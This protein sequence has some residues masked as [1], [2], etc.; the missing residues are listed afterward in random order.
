ME[1]SH[2]AFNLLQTRRVF[3]LRV[4]RLNAVG[5]GNIAILDPDFQ[6]TTSALD[7]FSLTP[8]FVPTP[9]CDPHPQILRQVYDFVRKLQWRF[10]FSFSSDPPRF[11]MRNSSRWPPTKSV[12]S[13][14]ARM[15]RK[16]IAGARELCGQ[17]HQCHFPDNLTKSQQREVS[18]LTSCN[19]TV[20][21]ADKGGRWTVVPTSSYVAEAN[22]QLSNTT[23]YR[24]IDRPPAAVRAKMNQLL[25]HL[26]QRKFITRREYNHF[27]PAAMN[28]DTR[29]FKLLPKLHKNTWPDPHMPPGRPI[30]SDVKSISRNTSELI[31]FFLKPL[32]AKLP[33]HLR[34]T[35]HLVAILRETSISSSSL[36][37]TLDVE[38]LYTSIPIDEGLEAVSRAF[39]ANPSTS[40]PDLTILSLLRLILTTNNF[41]FNGQ[42]WLQ[43]HG[44]AMGKV[45]GGS[46][47]NTFL[48]QWEKRAISTFTHSVSLWRRFQDDI[49]GIWDHGE[50]L[51]HQFVDHLNEQNSNIRVQLKYGQSV[52]FLDLHITTSGSTLRYSVFFKDT[53][54]H[55]ILPP[56][57]HHPASTFDGLLYGEIYRFLT[58]SSDFDSFS[59]TLKTVTPVW[60]AQGYPR[61]AIRRAKKR[62]MNTTQIFPTREPGMFP[63]SS[64]RCLVCPYANFLNVFD[65]FN[66]TLSYPIL[67]FLTCESTSVVYVIECSSCGMRYVGQTRRTLR[68]RILE[69]LRNISSDSHSRLYHHFRNVCK[70]N[71][72]TF[73]AISRHN[74]D[75]T[76]LAKE[77]AWISAL[78]TLHPRG[79]NSVPESADQPTN[80]ILPFDRCAVRLANAIRHWTKVPFRVTYTRTQNI[81]E[82]LSA[83]P[84]HR[85]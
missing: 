1:F 70:T 13:N 5:V 11:R 81:G 45:F 60:R 75:S 36:L 55:L 12:P 77:R 22:R 33:S 80:L 31:D 83:R 44:V 10:S 28:R 49:L 26:L 78:C 82:L 48:G 68:E 42:E 73:F 20:T 35:Q 15:S 43:T 41:N 47:A 29:S 9:Y 34:D 52:D 19:S 74:N 18:R 66:N 59:A 25:R 85:N 62:V 40:R 14:I 21:S 72:F 37:F 16:I 53:D 3:K 39:L 64:P 57:S 7:I 38:S 61:A 6:L 76:R 27:R 67:H 50:D 23:F 65:D 4:T 24:P 56:K 8:G 84:L 17:Q 46:F 54:G 63:C 58:H 32:C 30:V 51:L 71:N 79:L 2:E 69:H